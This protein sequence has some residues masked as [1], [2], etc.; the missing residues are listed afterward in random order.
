MTSCVLYLHKVQIFVDCTYGI[1]PHPFYQLF[2]VMV[3]DMARRIYIP[4]AWVLMTG[5]TTECYWQ[6]FNWLTSAVQD[7]D[8]TYFGVDFERA[9]F[10]N[11]RIHFENAKLLGCL[12]HFKQALRRKMKQLLFPDEEVIF[13]MKRGVIDVLTV[14]PPEHLTQGVTF[15]FCKIIDFLQELYS[16][17]KT[18]F[19]AAKNRWNT[20]FFEKYF[21]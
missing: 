12:F 3:F 2:I 8:P 10:T 15:V 11:V 16:G 5:K 17:D 21:L 13:A 4:C 18:K 9:F 19:G 7:M 1:V 14:I 20:E 6:V